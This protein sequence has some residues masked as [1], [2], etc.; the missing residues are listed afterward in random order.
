MTRMSDKLRFH[1]RV[2]DDLRAAI[3][4]YDEIS[5]ELGNRFRA[6]VDER[7]DGIE[8]MPESYA[9]AID[10]LRFGRVGSF[11]YI[12]LFRVRAEVVHVLGLFHTSTDM[13]QWKARAAES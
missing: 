6:Q 12:L 3:N 7:F 8:D 2:Y 11:P 5:V 1:P 13:A 10:D 4:W 9:I